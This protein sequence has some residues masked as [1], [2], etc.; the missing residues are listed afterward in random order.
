MRLDEQS[1]AY[2]LSFF[3]QGLNKKNPAPLHEASMAIADRP[4][5]A[6]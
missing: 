6:R 5:E 1:L 4:R 2:F 3:M